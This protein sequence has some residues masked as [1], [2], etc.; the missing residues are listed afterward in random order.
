MITAPGP[1]ALPAPLL[2]G[3]RSAVDVGG[4]DGTLLAALLHAHP[5]LTGVLFE[6][7]A[8]AARAACGP[9]SDPDL[10]G[11]ATIRL[12]HAAAPVPSGHD[13]YLLRGTLP[14]PPE[15]VALPELLAMVRA[16]MPAG[17]RILLLEPPPRWDPGLLDHAGLRVR[18][19]GT[20]AVL[21]PVTA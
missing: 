19:A 11:R 18:L 12:A 20:P 6:R 9:L 15:P 8:L 10:R 7:P 2:D 3:A 17:A 1:P 4:G 13:V 14:G 21:D 5:G 16:A